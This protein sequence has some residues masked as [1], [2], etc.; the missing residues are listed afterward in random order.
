MREDRDD[1]VDRSGPARPVQPDTLLGLS[2][3]VILV[4][5]LP[6]FSRDLWNPDEPRLAHVAR[7]MLVTGDWLVPRVNGDPFVEQPP[8]QV[9]LIAASMAVLGH[10]YGHDWVPRLP[11]IAFGLATLAL[12]FTTVS[13]W[14]GRRAALLAVVLLVTTVEFFVGH[15]RAIVDTSLTFFV[16]LAM[17]GVID[18]VTLP[19]GERMR[20]GSA[21]ALGAAIGCSF[22]AKNL[23][24]AAYVGLVVVAL[25][26]RFPSRLLRVHALARAGV[27]LAVALLVA[28][29]W[30]I[31]L[32]SVDPELLRELLLDNTIGRFTRR[33]IHN[34]PVLEFLHRGPSVL[35]PWLPVPAVAFIQRARAGWARSGAD[36][37]A[38]S[39]LEE[40]LLWWIVLPFA[41]VLAS[42]SK[43][44]I[45]L[46]PITPAVAV[47][48]ALWLD[49]RL[50]HRVVR[51]IS[52]VV[53][54][55]A[56]LAV[57]VAALLGGAWAAPLPASV[58]L[59]LL[60]SLALAYRLVRGRR[61]G[62]ESPDAARPAWYSLA[63]LLCALGAVSGVYFRARNG[64][65]S[66]ID[67]CRAL[68][69]L[70]RDGYGIL[71]HFPLSSED[72]VA[73]EEAA[74]SYYLEERLENVTSID[75]LVE[76]FRDRSR[77]VVLVYKAR[78]GDAFV[79]RL[80]HFQDLGEYR[81]RRRLRVIANLARDPA[82]NTG[83]L[84]D[85]PRDPGR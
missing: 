51:V 28:A 62:G 37:P 10:G 20:W 78:D 9:W 75:R 77:P 39:R 85:R 40:G 57:L 70:R 42:G 60:L 84:P 46:L 29:P 3:L 82:V 83:P 76:L 14:A 72:A 8:L 81:V 43:R 47:A 54:A 66:Y 27:A 55:V 64:R 63:L 49:A 69:S 58:W 61:N 33:D 36:R 22:L 13:R 12:V 52:F 6:A 71:L 80:E 11:S 2:V 59:F 32:A 5:L 1:P 65:E 17:V 21:V 16:T 19:D 73:R 34:P 48:S 53:A 4:L 23:V 44:E 68:E 15:Q 41:L 50:S 38:R 56:S 35:L 31:A 25:A 7:E 74:I 18:F 26:I 67:L 24:G 79:D 30:P 45:Y